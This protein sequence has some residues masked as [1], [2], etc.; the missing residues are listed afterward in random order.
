MIE[1]NL[2]ILIVF[3][4]YRVGRRYTISYSVRL[5]PS[6]DS[7]ATFSYVEKVILRTVR[8]LGCYKALNLVSCYIYPNPIVTVFHEWNS[9]GAKLLDMF[10]TELTVFLYWLCVPHCSTK[11]FV[12]G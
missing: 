2:R 11:T 4:T 12:A 5:V 9:F 7:S 8:L 10:F 6:H 1:N 3:C